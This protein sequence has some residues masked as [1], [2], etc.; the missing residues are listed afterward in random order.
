[1]DIEQMGRIYSGY[2]HSSGVFWQVT[3]YPMSPNEQKELDTYL[4]ENLKS[5]HKYPSKSPMASPVFFV[6]KKDRNLR[7]M[8]DYRKL[9][10]ITIKTAYPLP[11]VSDIMNKI[12]AGKAKYFRKLNVHW[13]YNNVC[14]KEGDEWKCKVSTPL[15]PTSALNLFLLQSS[16]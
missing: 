13:G 2:M 11:L 14:L 4:E 6:K 10:D 15:Y 8:Q 1:M 12:A 16:K 5:H 7:F 3:T 9:N